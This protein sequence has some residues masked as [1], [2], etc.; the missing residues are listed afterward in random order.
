MCCTCSYHDNMSRMI[1]LRHVPDELHRTLKA[2]AA[3]EGMSLSDYLLNQVRQIAERP[4]VDELRQR[5]ARRAPVVT[6]VPPVRAVRAE[7]NQA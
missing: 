6:R 2:R 4:T 3:M 1:Q 7:R 5:L